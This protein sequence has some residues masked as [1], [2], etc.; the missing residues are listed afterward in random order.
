M[1]TFDRSAKGAFIRSLLGAR[2]KGG[3]RVVGS[4]GILADINVLVYETNQPNALANW[5]A[6]VAILSEAYDQFVFR[7]GTPIAIRI[8]ANNYATPPNFPDGVPPGASVPVF[9]QYLVINL[10]PQT[11]GQP[12]YPVGF[13]ANHIISMLNSVGTTPAEIQEF[14]GLGW[15]T[16]GTWV[17]SLS[18]LSVLLTELGLPVN[19]PGWDMSGLLGATRWM[20]RLATILGHWA[21]VYGS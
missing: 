4:F 9:F 11:G 1:Q 6:D 16:S 8:I 18:P 21:N 12:K 13:T 19:Q 10:A 2:N 15:T 7:V 17:S 3:R 14:A 5:N 20:P